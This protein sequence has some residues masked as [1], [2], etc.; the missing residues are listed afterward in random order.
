M[1]DYEWKMLMMAGWIGPNPDQSS[2]RG[3]FYHR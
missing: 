3:N 1:E 2:Q